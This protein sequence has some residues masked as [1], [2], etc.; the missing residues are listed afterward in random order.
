MGVRRDL[1]SVDG[2]D[3]LEE[4]AGEVEEEKSDSPD[5]ITPNGLPCESVCEGR[6]EEEEFGMRGRSATFGDLCARPR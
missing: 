4:G 1:H 5:A 3:L 6:D 2:M